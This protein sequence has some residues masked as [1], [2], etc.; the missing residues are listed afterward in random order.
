VGFLGRGAARE[1]QE[2]GAHSI[3]CLVAAGEATVTV[4]LVRVAMVEE[5]SSF[6]SGKRETRLRK[7]LCHS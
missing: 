3:W 5:D 4:E 2:D 6:G 7:C 1:P